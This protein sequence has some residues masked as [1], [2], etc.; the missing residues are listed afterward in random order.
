MNLAD[1]ITL[2]TTGLILLQGLKAF[3]QEK[4]KHQESATFGNAG[5]WDAWKEIVF[6]NK[7][8]SVVLEV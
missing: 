1:N 3:L 2:D 4:Q 7:V 5:W 8:Y 6:H